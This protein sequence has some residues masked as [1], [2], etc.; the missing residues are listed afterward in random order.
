[1]GV[2]RE[3]TKGQCRQAQNRAFVLLH[4]L[5]FH[6]DQVSIASLDSNIPPYMETILDGLNSGFS[7]PFI[8]LG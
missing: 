8:G 3:S 6:Q 7:Q 4:E 5:A 1:M 2:Y